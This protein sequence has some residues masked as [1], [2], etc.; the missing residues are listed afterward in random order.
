MD[1][2][3][4]FVDG[5][6]TSKFKGKWF[7]MM[8]K[9]PGNTEPNPPIETGPVTGVYFES[10]NM[11]VHGIPSPNPSNAWENI[12]NLCEAA[13]P[14]AHKFHDEAPMVIFNHEQEMMAVISLNPRG[15][16]MSAAEKLASLEKT[17]PNR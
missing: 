3:K 5:F 2:D 7:Y 8:K 15:G 4:D 9:R 12:R 13:L 16:A 17:K 11:I 14:V 6:E 1:A 10:T